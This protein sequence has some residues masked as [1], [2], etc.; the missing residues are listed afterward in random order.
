MMRKM[1]D[2]KRESL[3]DTKTEGSLGEVFAKTTKAS[4]TGYYGKS[5]YSTI[6]E[7]RGGVLALA[8]HVLGKL[9][10]QVWP[11]SIEGSTNGTPEEG[12]FGTGKNY[13]TNDSGEKIK[14]EIITIDGT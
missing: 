5:D 3:E 11:F 13:P 4:V 9:W 1:S 8:R 14:A 2:K 6:N 10:R 12:D 7:Y